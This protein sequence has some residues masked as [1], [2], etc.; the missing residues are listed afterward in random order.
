MPPVD[1]F[2]AMHK[3]VR[4]LVYDQASRLQSADFGDAAVAETTLDHVGHA[5]DLLHEH[6]VHEERFVF[7]EL[8]RFDAGL[9]DELQGAHRTIDK[10]IEAVRAAVAQT[11]EAPDA[12]K[13]ET[14][15]ELNRRFNELVAFSLSHNNDEERRAVAATTRYFSGEELAAMRMGMQASQTRER[16]AEWAR[17]VLPALSLPELAGLLADMQGTVPPPAFEGATRVARQALGEE[18]WCE[19]ALAAGL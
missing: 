17:W 7:S 15:A 14:G 11:A 6:A 8:R 13:L 4:A 10:K 19:V 9:A 16:A 18:K 3:G 12:G 5:L 2:T 1:L